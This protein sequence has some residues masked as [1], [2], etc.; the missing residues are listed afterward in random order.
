MF[1]K[2]ITSQ[3][4]AGSLK[5]GLYT[6]IFTIDGERYNHKLIVIRVELD[7]KKLKWSPVTISKTDLFRTGEKREGGF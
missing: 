7:I 2:N 1:E 3:I 4:E 5:Q 6:V